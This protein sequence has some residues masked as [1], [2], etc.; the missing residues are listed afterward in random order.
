[1]GNACYTDH[2]SFNT[3]Y[4]VIDENS[5]LLFQFPGTGDEEMEP[6]PF[7]LGKNT[8]NIV[9]YDV[10][11]R[12]LDETVSDAMDDYLGKKLDDIVISA[13]RA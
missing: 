8:L 6:D 13:D 4:S 7:L 10:V 3:D 11:Q 9:N 2:G 12:L 5:P 1:M